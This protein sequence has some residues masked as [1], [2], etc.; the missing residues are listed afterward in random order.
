MKRTV[1]TIL[2]IMLSITFIV[3]TFFPRAKAVDIK[4]TYVIPTD[5]QGTVGEDV[6]VIGTIN[7]TD[8][9]Y[10][11][12]FD[13]NKVV[14]AN[15][16]ANSVNATFTVPE[17]P[18]GN[19]TITLHDFSL[20][21]NTTTWFYIDTAYHI[22][23]KPTVPLESTE[24]LQ[25]GST[26]EV[27]VNVT[28][29]QLNKAY[30]ANI[31]VKT[32]SNTTYWTLATLTN[33]TDTGEGHNITIVYPTHFSGATYTNYVGTYAVAFNRTLAT[34]KF[35][36]GLTNFTEYH[37][38]QTVNVKAVGYQPNENATIKIGFEGETI[39]STNTTAST[40]GVI[41]S[42]WKVPS[43]ASIGTYTVNI[44][45][46][47]GSTIK[48]PPDIQNFAVPGFDINITT[49]GLAGD[50]AANVMVTIFEKDEVLA[51]LTNPSGSIQTELEVG[52]YTAKAVY[53]GESV[54][55]LLINV[56]ETASLDFNCNLTNLKISVFAKVDDAEIPIPQ[57]EVY[58]TS[59]PENRSSSTNVTGIMIANLLLPNHTYVLNASRYGASFNVTSIP[60]LLVNGTAVAWYNVT[61]I[62]PTLTLQVN[63]TKP[64][65]EP[66]SNVTVK[67]QES[68]G[69]LLYEGNTNA[70]GIVIFNCAFG[71]YTIAVYDADGIK[72]NETL[73]ELFQNNNASIV[74]RLYDLTISFRVVDFFGQPIPNVNVTLQR[75]N[76]ALR[77]S[78]TLAD[79]LATFNNV[80]GGNLLVSTYLF[81]QMR[82]EVAKALYVENSTIIEIK[83]LEYV[84]L[85]GFFIQTATLT[86]TILIVATILLILFMEVYRRRRFK[87]QK[88]PKPETE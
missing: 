29:G 31:T 54:G 80:T 43:N 86:T 17:L 48:N 76:V 21:A 3:A 71:R 67:V 37:R 20:N 24:Q 46:T 66:I 22:E 87:P 44:T 4:I 63:T 85:A 55:E 45:S 72:L 8:G 60:T 10:Q 51:N 82:P 7:T 6:H 49:K 19:Y 32:P 16:T 50:I 2:I 75:E 57:V 11:I 40:E 52:N 62:T 84:I 33:I 27:W 74:C 61:L 18:Q 56:T 58:L 30:V 35:I 34:D 13:Q 68:L 1:A 53:K 47:S 70:E 88:I 5:H 23:A 81:N 83:L 9:L 79:G 39:N 77:S 73:E 26:V 78:R 15:A 65:S 69:G 59:S 36:I 38:Y 64:N 41:A 42:D 14:E 25:E 28:G 12:W